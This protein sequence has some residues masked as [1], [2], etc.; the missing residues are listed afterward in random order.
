MPRRRSFD[1][2]IMRGWL[3][4][5]IIYVLLYETPMHGKPLR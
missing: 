2:N 5:Y 4:S 1:L 3:G